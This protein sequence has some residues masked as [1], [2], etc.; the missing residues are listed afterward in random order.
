MVIT[1]GFQI[2]PIC[3]AAQIFLQVFKKSSYSTS[4]KIPVKQVDYKYNYFCLATEA[5]TY[6]TANQIPDLAQPS[7]LSIKYKPNHQLLY[8][9]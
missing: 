7:T 3:E 6:H 9:L 2:A 8:K 4:N 5:D 1:P